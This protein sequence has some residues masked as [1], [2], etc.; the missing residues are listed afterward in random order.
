[1]GEGMAMLMGVQKKTAWKS[2]YVELL[3]ESL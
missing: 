1:M 3:C 2:S